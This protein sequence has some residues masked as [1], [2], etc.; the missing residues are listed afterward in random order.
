MPWFAAG[1]SI[2]CRSSP[3]SISATT[4]I[5]L[6]AILANWGYAPNSSKKSERMARISLRELLVSRT[7]STIPRIKLRLVSRFEQ[8]VNNSSN[9]SIKIKHW[10]WG[11]LL[12]NSW[13]ILVKVSLFPLR[14]NSTSSSVKISS[15]W[16]SKLRWKVTK[17]SRLGVN[18]KLWQGVSDKSSIWGI[19]PALTTEDLPLPEAPKTN[20][21]LLWF[22]AW[23]SLLI[24][25]SRP[26]NKCLCLAL[27]FF[28]PL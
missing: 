13:A 8:I 14:T 22:T 11:Y 26:K 23:I 12:L 7:K 24:S 18:R 15:T 10:D 25:R 2:A 16:V 9:W 5:F 28:S 19:T 3:S 17:G 1:S 6:A 20:T 27:N 21:K 4:S